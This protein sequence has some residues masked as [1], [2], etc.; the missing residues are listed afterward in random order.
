MGAFPDRAVGP[1]SAEAADP[2]GP[3]AMSLAEAGRFRFGRPKAV[4][5][6]GL[7]APCATGRTEAGRTRSAHPPAAVE[8]RL[9]FLVEGGPSGR[10]EGASVDVWWDGGAGPSCART[11][12]LASASASRVIEVRAF[13]DCMRIPLE[14][15][16][17]HRHV[18]GY[19]PLWLPIPVFNLGIQ[20]AMPSAP[21]SMSTARR[22]SPLSSRSASRSLRAGQS[23][24][25]T[26]KFAAAKSGPRRLGP[27]SLAA[28]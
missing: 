19:V 11:E 26:P 18:P 16:G 13:A 21:K 24:S 23:I 1:T 6:V 17:G 22:V 28:Q 8:R 12:V 27:G 4:D 3:C 25:T 5:A 14:T 9:A 2:A 7:A 20:V 15:G 10:P